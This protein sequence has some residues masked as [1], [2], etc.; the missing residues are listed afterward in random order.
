L[1]NYIIFL[2]V[3]SKLKSFGAVDGLFLYLQNAQNSSFIFI[4]S[5]QKN[6]GRF[7]MIPNIKLKKFS[8]KINVEFF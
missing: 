5:F 6:W 7:I 8:N 1:Y 2:N 3:K 4:L